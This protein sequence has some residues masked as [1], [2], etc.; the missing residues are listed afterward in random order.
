MVAAKT[1]SHS[2]IP[3]RHA[4]E[5]VDMTVIACLRLCFHFSDQEW[6]SKAQ[7][8]V[9]NAAIAGSANQSGYPGAPSLNWSFND[10]DEAKGTDPL[11]EDLVLNLC[12]GNVPR[13]QLL[14]LVAEN[15]H[16]VWRQLIIIQ[17]S[18][19]MGGLS[20]GKAKTQPLQTRRQGSQGNFGLM[21]TQASPVLRQEPAGLHMT[22][23]WT[24][25]LSGI[26]IELQRVSCAAR[27]LGPASKGARERV[28]ERERG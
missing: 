26:I 15:Q 16:G 12:D 20:L 23:A 22:P 13:C 25:S 21:R 5:L 1:H 2:Y 14:H 24:P 17:H 11:L 3:K 9:A 18:P 4:I 8:E 19:C 27:N 10:L 6:K 7:R 28:E